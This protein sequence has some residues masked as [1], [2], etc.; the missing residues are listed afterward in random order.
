MAAFA[1]NPANYGLEEKDCKRM[2]QA[3][4]ASVTFMD[5]QL[6][7]VLDALDRLKLADNTIIVF[8]SDHG[9]HLGEHGAWQK[10]SLFEESARVPLIVAAPGLKGNG[11]AC[12][13]VAELV[14]L[15][16]TL[17]DLCELKPPADLA[18]VSLKAQLND[19]KAPGKAGAFT[20]VKRGQI[21]GRTVRTERWRY[22]EWDDGKA[23]VELYDHDADP[24]ETKNLADD[25]KLAET[26][27]QLRDLLHKEK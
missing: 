14:D 10:M 1:V 4:Y 11:K 22:T 3:Y 9:W 13:R 12:G 8:T 25:P 21:M 15:Y 23:G 7:R 27:K 2:I 6:G 16:P 19:V 5:A 18:G 17:A 26:V 20:Q 24:Q